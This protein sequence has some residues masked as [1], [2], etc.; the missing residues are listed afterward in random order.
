MSVELWVENLRTHT[1]IHETGTPGKISH[2]VRGKKKNPVA[3]SAVPLSLAHSYTPNRPGQAT[4][5]T[6]PASSVFDTTSNYAQKWPPQNFTTQTMDTKIR[7]ISE[8]VARSRLSKN[9]NVHTFEVNCWYRRSPKLYSEC[10]WQ[11]QTSN[12]TG[13]NFVHL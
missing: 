10:L 6:F 5:E 8:K 4:R 9:I 7:N 2:L 3:C 11:F 12:L 1:H 13:Y